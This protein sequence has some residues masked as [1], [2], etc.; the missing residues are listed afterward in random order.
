MAEDVRVRKLLAE[1]RADRQ[2]LDVWRSTIDDALPRAPWEPGSETLLAVAVALHHWYGAAE[3]AFERIT[4]T[5][6]GTPERSERWHQS[7]L[8]AVT[9]D[10]PEVRPAVI[11]AAIARD[12]RRLLGFR[13]FFRHA[14]AIPFDPGELERLARV[15][16]QIHGRLAGELDGFEAVLHRSL[17]A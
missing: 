2:A 4:R 9:L 7:L 8:D 15:L 14:Y 3:A 11:S 10:I 13:H 17:Q 5:F 1:V 6:E 12:L 16:A